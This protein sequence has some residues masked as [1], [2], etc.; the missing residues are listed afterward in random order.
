L[1]TVGSF[2]ETANFPV[3]L[4][5]E[6]SASEKQG[7]GR[8][9]HWEMVFWW[10]RKPLAGARAVIAGALIPEDA[11]P[12]EFIHN[13]R[14]AGGT[15]HSRNPSIPQ[16][17]RNRISRARLLDPFAG[18]GSIPLEAIRLGVGEVVAVELLPTAYIFL[19]AV[20][21]YP[22]WAVDNNVSQKLIKDVEKWGEWVSQRLR[23]DPEIRELYDEDVAVYIGTWEIKC[24]HCGLYTPLVGNWWLARVSGRSSAEDEE[25][26]GSGRGEY[27]RLAWMEFERAGKEISIRIV[28][29]NK[30]IGTKRVRAS[31]DATRGLVEAGGRR[32]SVPQKN[33][34]AR[35]ES[36]TCLHCG[37]QIGR[38]GGE[39]LVKK[40]LKEYNQNL[41][42]YLSGEISL[43]ALRESPARPK[44]LA[45]VRIAGG[46]LEFQ[47]ASKEDIE[48]LWRVL[49]KLRNIWGDPD[50]PTEELPYYDQEFARTH[51]WG[52][53]KFYKLFNPRQLLTLV[54]LVKLIREAG[55]KVEEEKLREGWEREKAHKYAEAIATYLAIILINHMRH[56]CVVTS[57]EPTQKFI[58]HA[59]AFRGIAMTWN[60]VE[61]YPIADVIGS[62]TRSIKSGID[63]LSYLVSAVSGSPS[64]VR[65]LLD[66][67][68]EL[69]RVGDERFDLIVTDPPYR[70]DVAYAELSDFYYV[71]LKRALSDVADVGGIPVRIP[72]FLPEAFFEDGSEIEVQ[73]KVFAPREVSEADG[74][75]RYF[76]YAN[77]R[78][79][80]SFDHFKDLLARSFKS[81]ASR[82]TDGGAL[83]TY[84]AHTSPDAWEALLEAGWVGAGLRITAAHALAT[85]STQRVTAR[86]KAS[87]DISIV[88][89][90]RRGSSGQELAEEVYWRAVEGCTGYAGDLY[91]SGLRD[92][93]L[94]VG[95]LGCVLSEFTRYE[96]VIGADSVKALVERYVYPATAEAI[97][98]MLGGEASARLRGSS[99]FYLLAKVLVDRRARQRRRSLDRSSVNILAIGTRVSLEELARQLIIRRG[100]EG[101]EL[102]EP[103]WG[104]DPIRSLREVLEERGIDPRNPSPRNAVDLLHI[105]EYYSSTLPSS[106]LSG[107]VEE[108]RSRYPSLYEETISLARLIPR[109][110]EKVDPEAELAGKLVAFVEPSSSSGLERWV[111]R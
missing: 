73:W 45:K 33:V 75:S 103:A 69:G 19:K 6:A 18:F 86:G 107:R 72:R 12:A 21:E 74:R 77:S 35:R 67:A 1:I 83:V 109:V 25:E 13:L 15:A 93:D 78:G 54:K 82:P 57:V 85:E 4:V 27:K 49:E 62:F 9:P 104:Q 50:I 105:M 48:R 3:K 91:R 94:F 14:L 76:G 68:T 11:I 37:N 99:L 24:P 40:A 97:A 55:K 64:R 81:M 66:D 39:W 88:A 106:E 42:K 5:N 95:V 44:L 79:V 10:T 23:E 38:L 80:G 110:L 87:L 16:S 63:G 20:L 53:D 46:D 29:L 111:R 26:E 41:E 34:D 47:P 61:E 71:W 56:N 36:A 84:Y 52:F 22:K 102:L 8:P 100:G 30:E 96:K 43:E 58:A 70:D 7:G 92:V 51:I 60:W 31:V 59:L 101:F 108:L 90:W 98:R 17:W 2:I 28:D 89:V 65:V 32:Y